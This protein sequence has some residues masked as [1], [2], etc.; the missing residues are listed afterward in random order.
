M[1]RDLSTFQD[2]AKVDAGR[3]AGH[4]A[5]GG[6]IAMPLS[7][8]ALAAKERHS[9]LVAA[10]AKRKRARELAL[11]TNDNEVKLEL[12]QLDEPVCVFGE[13]PPERRE[14]LRD[15]LAAALAREDAAEPDETGAIGTSVTDALLAARAAAA[16]LAGAATTPARAEAVAAE[17]F[18]TEGTPA[19]R[20]ARLEIAADSLRRAATRLATEQAA[21]AAE[22]GGSAAARA[23]SWG[24]RAAQRAVAQLVGL[25]PQHSASPDERPLSALA[26]SKPHAPG[27]RVTLAVGGWGG[28]VRLVSLPECEPTQPAFRAH[29]ERIGGLAFHPDAAALLE[30][31]ATAAIARYDGNGDDAHG[32][33]CCGDG[34]A[35][36]AGGEGGDR[37][38]SDLVCLAT[39]GGDGIARLWPA[40]PTQTHS[41][42]TPSDVTA[43][44]PTRAVNGRSAEHATPLLELRGH[45][46]RLGRCAFHPAGG[47]LATTS[48]DGTWRLWDV[49]TGVELLLQEGHSRA[50]YCVAFQ[51]DGALVASA[52]L[53][54]LVRVWD[55]R[56]GKCIQ[57]FPGHHRPILS[58]AASPDGFTFASGSADHTVR[59]WDCRKRRPL[60]VL[61]AHANLV[62]AVAFGGSSESWPH[63]GAWLLSASF[64]GTLRAWDTA[65]QIG[66]NLKTARAHEARVT[67]AALSVDDR[68]AVTCS[69]DRTWKLWARDDAMQRRPRV[70]VAL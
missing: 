27:G 35:D 59:L 11:P 19:L 14:R 3:A 52:G 51:P 13:G 42:L 44:E 48:F 9:A 7:A 29:T 31:A 37:S 16:Q 40:R 4:I 10:L 67:D 26:L 20:A 55:C 64:D 47:H 5:G 65:L 49:R 6:A 43:S 21:R 68:F 1:K 50:V 66:G 54:A 24:V 60:A 22:S 62:S 56:S 33:A 12:R 23:T 36:A 45:T 61:A 63:A 57:A 69:F 28:T 2:A 38:C 41:L 53:D 34:A 58:L 30:R 18:Y 39:A 17:L 32:D 8:A 25:Q 15:V 46:D 70:H